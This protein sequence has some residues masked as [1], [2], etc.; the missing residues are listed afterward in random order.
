MRA[1]Y[2]S[3]QSNDEHRLSIYNS[4]KQKVCVVVLIF[5]PHGN[6]TCNGALQT[7]DMMF[8]CPPSKCTCRTSFG[9]AVQKPNILGDN[10]PTAPKIIAVVT[11][12]QDEHTL[13]GLH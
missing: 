6:I 3:L 9:N 4:I 1:V 7:V 5:R 13:R 10:S 8:K 2:D 12:R 11:G